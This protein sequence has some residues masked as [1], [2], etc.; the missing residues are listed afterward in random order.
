MNQE[1]TLPRCKSS[2]INYNTNA[3]MISGSVGVGSNA[4]YQASVLADDS[5]QSPGNSVDLFAL[6]LELGKEV[7]TIVQR[8]QTDSS[9]VSAW[10]SKRTNVINYMRQGFFIDKFRHKRKQ[11]RSVD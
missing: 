11:R 10:S 3:L 8:L 5:N 7:K 1:P 2:K 6:T 9:F 4:D